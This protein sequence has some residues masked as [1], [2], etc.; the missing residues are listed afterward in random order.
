MG[1]RKNV[2][3]I[4]RIARGVVGVALSGLGV[5]AFLAGEPVAGVL[6]AAFGVGLLSNAATQYCVV[7]AALG[8]DTCPRK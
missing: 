4:D 7:N 1:G 6:A 5:G 2:G 8:I 3:G